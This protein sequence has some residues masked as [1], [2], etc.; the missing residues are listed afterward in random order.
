MHPAKQN[1]S[2]KD[3][4]HPMHCNWSFYSAEGKKC[5]D[6]PGCLFK[7]SLHA[8]SPATW[9]KQPKRNTGEQRVLLRWDQPLLTERVD[10]DEK[11]R[12]GAEVAA[13]AGPAGAQPRTPVHTLA[14]PWMGP[15]SVLRCWWAAI[16]ESSPSGPTHSVKGTTMQLPW[17]YYFISSSLCGHQFLFPLPD[18]LENSFREWRSSVQCD[19]QTEIPVSYPGPMSIHNTVSSAQYNILSKR[20]EK[21]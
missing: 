9:E 11:Q 13:E 20:K 7:I 17:L 10:R 5:S 6:W 2:T 12:W 15:S 19:H 14:T 4:L 18:P 3:Y 21:E 16:T 1:Q 8:R